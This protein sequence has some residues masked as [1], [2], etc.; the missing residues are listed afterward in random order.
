MNP[1]DKYFS[2]ED[3]LHI[4]CCNF[5]DSQYPKL[6]YTHPANEAKRTTFERYK[7]KKMRMKP[8]VPDLLIFHPNDTF[9]GLAV[10]L[11]VGKNKLSDYQEQWKEQLEKNGWYY[12]TCYDLDNFIALIKDYMD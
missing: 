8:G 7:A 9:N 2:A 11:K 5:L 1:Y 12:W 4:A 6:L 10:E 3:N